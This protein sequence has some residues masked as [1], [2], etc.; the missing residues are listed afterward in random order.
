MT[1][2]LE[3]ATGKYRVLCALLAGCGPLR[4]GDALGLEVDKHISP[5]FRTLYIQQNVKGFDVP[6]SIGQ[7]RIVPKEA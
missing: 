2:I 6:P 7:L 3:K 4:A 5:F 1:K